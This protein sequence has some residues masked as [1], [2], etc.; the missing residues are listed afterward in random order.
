M[1][2]FCVNK[3][4]P[5]KRIYYQKQDVILNDI[6]GNK[7]NTVLLKVRRQHFV[8]FLFVLNCVTFVRCLDFLKSTY[9][10]CTCEWVPYDSAYEVYMVTYA[11]TEMMN[12]CWLEW[13]TDLFFNLFQGGFVQHGIINKRK[14][15]VF[16]I[17]LVRAWNHDLLSFTSSNFVYFQWSG[18]LR[19]WLFDKLL[20]DL[21]ICLLINLKL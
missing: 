14:F 16:R 5:K 7:F 18:K 19:Y 3:S 12:W 1:F 2:L 17:C 4:L 20:Y 10:L 13:Y 21:L 11:L 9:N 15:W 8:Q 6:F